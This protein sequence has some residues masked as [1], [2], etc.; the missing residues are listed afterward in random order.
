[1]PSVALACQL[2]EM[3][4]NDQGDRVKLSIWDTA[5]SERYTG[6]NKGYFRGSNAAVIVYDYTNRKSYERV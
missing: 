6:M 4:Y 3:A 1:M 2:K 5:G